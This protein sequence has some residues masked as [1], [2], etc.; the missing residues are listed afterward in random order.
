MEPTVHE[1]FNIVEQLLNMTLL[2]TEWVLWLLL[3]LSV[4]SIGIIIER[5]IY[6]FRHRQAD[7]QKVRAAINSLFNR[8]IDGAQKVAQANQSNL[9]MAVI[10]EGISQINHGPSAQ[11]DCMRAYLLRQKKVLDR[12]LTV[13][14]TLGNNAPFIGLFGTV[15][16]IIKAFN[17]LGLNPAGGAT[18]VMAGISEAL[19]ATAVGLFVAIPAVVAFNYFQRVTKTVLTDSEAVISSVVAASKATRKA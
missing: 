12:G 2:G 4:V 15:L 18:V 14:A 16:G 17:D 8:D 19:V 1:G 6:F 3:I 11:E 5:A 10:L 7:P 9:E 13:L